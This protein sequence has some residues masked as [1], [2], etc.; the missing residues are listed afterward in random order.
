LSG[1]LKLQGVKVCHF[2]L[3]LHMGLNIAALTRCGDNN[4]H[5]CSTVL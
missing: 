2:P 4:V 5:L 1:T 3:N